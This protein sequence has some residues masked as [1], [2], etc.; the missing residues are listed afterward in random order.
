M[1]RS[2]LCKRCGRPFV[3]AWRQYCSDECRVARSPAVYR[4]ICPDGRSYV[5]SRNDCRARR[6]E[7]IKGSNARLRAALEQY[8]ADMWTYEVLQELPPGYWG[9]EIH[10]WARKVLV[11]ARMTREIDPEA[12]DPQGDFFEWVFSIVEPF[13][14]DCACIDQQELNAE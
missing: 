9:D 3:R 13:D 10:E 11:R 8:P 2:R 4:F 5:G 14:G 6:E 7:G 1:I 12:P